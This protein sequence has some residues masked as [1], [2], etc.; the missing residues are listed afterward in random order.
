M[1][2]LRPR[3]AQ[4]HTARPKGQESCLPGVQRVGG[5]ASCFLSK[6]VRGAQAMEVKGESASQLF[7]QPVGT[8]QSQGQDTP[9][10]LPSGC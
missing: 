4:G 1:E 9:S 3:E 8:A 7:P 10:F 6:E 2:K 5:A